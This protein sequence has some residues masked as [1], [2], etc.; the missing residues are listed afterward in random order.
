[1]AFS[2][3]SGTDAPKFGD[4][5][6]GGFGGGSGFSFGAAKPVSFDS[7]SAAASNPTPSSTL[8]SGF[9]APASQ[10]AVSFGSATGT[11]SSGF[12]GG[13]GTGDADIKPMFGTGAAATPTST[14]L[15]PEPSSGK[16]STANTASPAAAV[17]QDENVDDSQLILPELKG[18]AFSQT[19][20][21][22]SG[23]E[24]EEATFSERSKMYIFYKEDKYGDEVRL[25]MWKERGK[26]QLKILK[27]KLSGKYRLL[28]RQEATKKVICNAPILGSETLDF[29]SVKQVTMNV[30]DYDAEKNEYIARTVAFKLRGPPEMDSF[31]KAFD[32]ALQAAGGSSLST[33]PKTADKPKTESKTAETATPPVSFTA[34][35]TTAPAFTATPTAAPAV[36]FGSTGGG[37]G[38]FGFGGGGMP[39]DAASSSDTFQMGAASPAT[40][41][42][43]ALSMTSPPKNDGAPAFGA[44]S[45]GS[46]TGG[47]ATF[48]AASFGTPSTPATFGATAPLS[49][50]ESKTATP[51]SFSAT[52]TNNY[53]DLSLL[54]QNIP[55]TKYER[56]TQLVYKNCCARYRSLYNGEQPA[57]VVA[58]PGTLHLLGSASTMQHG[59]GAITTSTSNDRGVVLCCGGKLSSGSGALHHVQ[60]H[61]IEGDLLATDSAWSRVLSN[62]L[63]P[64]LG[65]RNAVMQTTLPTSSPF[66]LGHN[67]A[68]QVVAHMMQ[69]SSTVHAGHAT[70]ATVAAGS[71][72]KA[73][74]H[75]FKGEYG[76]AM[77]VSSDIS[78]TMNNIVCAVGPTPRECNE[79]YSSDG[80]LELEV[81]S[82]ILANKY[83]YGDVLTMERPTM[84]ALFEADFKKNNVVKSGKEWKQFADIL[85]DQKDYSIAEL[86]ALI[87]A[88]GEATTLVQLKALQA[89]ENGSSLRLQIKQHVHMAFAEMGAIETSTVDGLYKKMIVCNMFQGK[90]GLNRPKGDEM[91]NASKTIGGCG[92]RV[93]LP[94]NV[95]TPYVFVGVCSDAKAKAVMNA[96]KNVSGV[97]D[98]FATVASNPAGAVN[99]QE[100]INNDVTIDE[101]LSGMKM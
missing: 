3:G 89:G 25:N 50:V 1:M 43:S 83:Q 18:G 31:K 98:V 95:D 69:Q 5:P 60:D 71:S 52:T 20:A 67:N 88:G 55:L 94:A 45:F 97:V 33:L 24:Q 84:K 15:N 21:T 75:T 58:C 14:P 26:G 13:F 16:K 93:L 57:V 17:D 38:G 61:V 49:V 28:M 100:C 73:V 34:P 42:F 47:A 6:G 11:T 19:V 72:N 32:E 39:G 70:V 77:P 65:G 54:P 41:A 30:Q 91:F 79:T 74:L 82:L 59:M 66:A 46:S 4:S 35:T 9:S 92:G 12:N 62:V 99:V 2:F 27:H 68:M 48:G 78:M 8:T 87:P 96:L 76:S 80:S 53:C 44:A 40:N 23:E 36:S 56:R 90:L 7:P 37:G 22:K 10:S 85:V 63:D 81:F 101:L 86:L 29:P 64:K 51:S